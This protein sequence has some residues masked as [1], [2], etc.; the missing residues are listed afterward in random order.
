MPFSIQAISN[1]YTHG[2]GSAFKI[3]SGDHNMTASFDEYDGHHITITLGSD[4]M[5]MDV[6]ETDDGLALHI[7]GTDDDGERDGNSLL[8][9]LP[10]T[11]LGFLNEYDAS[12]RQNEE[13]APTPGKVIA[14][15]TMPDVAADA[16]LESDYD[17][18]HGD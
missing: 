10:I 14:F 11:L 6:D 18:K 16:H 7:H 12:L 5:H 3:G 8:I 2:R 13:D 15:P 9:V 1:P 17:D 4:E